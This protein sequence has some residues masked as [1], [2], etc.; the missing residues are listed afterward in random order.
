M[1]VGKQSL[2]DCPRLTW[3]LGWIGCLLPTTPPR[4]SIARFEITSFTFMLLWVPEP[5][6]HTTSGKWSSS[7][8]AITSSAARSIH[9]PSSG[10]R[11][12]LAT[13]T[14]AQAFLIVARARTTAVGIGSQPIG[15][16]SRLRWVCA[17]Q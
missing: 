4:S 15:K 7:W 9:S 8:P 13:F 17:P 12:P 16:F 14:A 3:S 1:A 2:E 11:P 5:V 10:E 6:C